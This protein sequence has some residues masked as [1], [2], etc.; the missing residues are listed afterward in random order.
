MHLQRKKVADEKMK[1]Y[2]EDDVNYGHNVQT[3]DSISL[4]WEIMYVGGIEGNNYVGV[5]AI[6]SFVM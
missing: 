5:Q 6:L 4:N 1:K 2:N 3:E